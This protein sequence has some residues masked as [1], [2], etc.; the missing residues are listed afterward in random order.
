MRSLV[1]TLSFL[2]LTITAVFSQSLSPDIIRSYE[3]SIVNKLYDMN[4]QTPLTVQQQWELAKVMYERDSTVTQMLLQKQT[5][6]AILLKRSEFEQ[7][8]YGMTVIRNYYDSVITR[9]AKELA[10][11]ELAS[12]S[13][14]HKTGDLSTTGLDKLFLAKYKLIIANIALGAISAQVSAKQINMLNTVI[15]SKT[16]SLLNVSFVANYF[17]RLDSVNRLSDT[18]KSKMAVRFNK[19]GADKAMQRPERMDAALRSYV[20]DTAIYARLYKNEIQREAHLLAQTEMR[21]YIRYKPSKECYDEIARF[22][23]EKSYQLALTNE[24]FSLSA[25]K[26]DSS[27]YKISAFYDSVIERSLYRD[28]VLVN[29]SYFSAAVK[30][31]KVLK[32]TSDQVDSLLDKGLALNRMKDSS[33]RVSPL[34]PIDTKD[35]ENLHISHI[36]RED[37]LAI[38]LSF[39]YQRDAEKNAVNDWNDLEK[40]GLTKDM[41]KQTVV[42]QLSSYYVQLKST[43]S[44]YAY[45]LEK[46]TAYARNIR[47][48]MPKAL[49]ILQY[50]RKNNVTSTSA[51]NLKIEW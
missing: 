47:D 50:A 40:R 3:P 27:H 13:T 26:R 36:L 31:R 32:L 4:R 15:Q 41:N 10:S 30:M 8:I 22:L 12:I 21:Q 48:N 2:F 19:L 20:T 45:D 33:W 43:S 39:K 25:R 14:Q 11:S 51:Q 6:S 24:S 17:K 49:K 5:D 29:A 18:I 16:D 28:G 1:A 35:F 9:S 38:L 7:K 34:A 44:M 42:R 37:Q 46:Q 23:G